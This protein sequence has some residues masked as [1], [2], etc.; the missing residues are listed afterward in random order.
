MYSWL[1]S[2]LQILI[3]C[4]ILDKKILKNARVLCIQKMTIPIFNKELSIRL[5]ER[6]YNLIHK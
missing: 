3:P 4:E 6:L 5:E 1:H 2:K